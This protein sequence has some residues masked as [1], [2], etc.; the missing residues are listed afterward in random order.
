[1]NIMKK[2]GVGLF[3]FARDLLLI[4]VLRLWLFLSKQSSKYGSKEYGGR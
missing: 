1:M 3:P 2:S 4:K